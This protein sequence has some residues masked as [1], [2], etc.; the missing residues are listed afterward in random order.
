M[1]EIKQLGSTTI[2]SQPSWTG[3]GFAE[4]EAQTFWLELPETL[5]RVATQEISAGNP[6]NQILRHHQ[7]GI[8]LL[9]F[10]R[11]PLTGNPSRTA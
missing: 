6:V 2:V 1:S 8:V 9:G 3:N 4:S 5:Q 7:R 10:S 11:G